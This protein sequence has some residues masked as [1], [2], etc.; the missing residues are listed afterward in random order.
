MFLDSVGQEL[1]RVKLEMPCLCSTVSGASARKPWMPGK[2]R[3][4]GGSNHLEVSS[5]TYLVC[6]QHLHVASLCSFYSKPAGFREEAFQNGASGEQVFQENQTKDREPDKRTRQKT[7]FYELASEVTS[8]ILCKMKPSQAY[9]DW[10]RE[11]TE[12]SPLD[13]KSV[14][15][16]R[17]IYK[18]VTRT[19]CFFSWAAR[20]S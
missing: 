5:L 7:E 1:G 2:D 10:K 3:N 9:L 20:E 11:G 17:A 19:K 15:V 13:G 12:T 16:S 8:A 4:V 6:Q 18:T 14:K